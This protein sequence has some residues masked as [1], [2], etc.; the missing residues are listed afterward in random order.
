MLYRGEKSSHRDAYRS[1][2]SMNGHGSSVLARSCN[3][4][5]SCPR[6]S[7]VFDLPVQ[8]YVLALPSLPAP[9]KCATF[10]G[11]APR[12][13]RVR[14]WVVAFVLPVR[15]F[16]QVPLEAPRFDSSTVGPGPCRLWFATSAVV[17]ASSSLRIHAPVIPLAAFRSRESGYSPGVL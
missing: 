12:R 8:Y 4:N 6:G 10:D 11:M 3:I 17:A 1:C 13:C 7:G 15:M 14:S 5:G 9:N 16:T 2:R